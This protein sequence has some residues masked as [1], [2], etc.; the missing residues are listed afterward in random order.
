MPLLSEHFKD[1]EKLKLTLVSDADHITKES[2]PGEYVRLIQE[3]LMKLANNPS[4]IADDEIRKQ[5]Y[6]D[7]TALA[8]LKYKQ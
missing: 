4:L 2:P 6:G 7:T 8:V 5:S 3:T 1:N